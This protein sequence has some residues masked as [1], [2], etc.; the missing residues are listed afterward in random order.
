MNSNKEKIWAIRNSLFF[1]VI[2]T[3]VPFLGTEYTLDKFKQDE[4]LIIEHIIKVLDDSNMEI[5]EVFTEKEN[6]E[7]NII[8]DIVDSKLYRIF[9]DIIRQ[10][11]VE[12]KRN[13]SNSL[14]NSI[15]ESHNYKCYYCG[16]SLKKEDSFSMPPHIDHVR[17]VRSGGKTK[18]SNLVAS[19][20]KCNIG[21]RDYDI[22]LYNG[23]D[24]ATIMEN[25]QLNP[26]VKEKANYSSVKSLNRQRKRVFLMENTMHKHCSK[27]GAI[28]TKIY[29]SDKIY[30]K[31]CS[32]T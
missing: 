24:E 2:R 4:P 10:H 17:S 18:E 16:S 19:C 6:Q 11:Y 25:G 22:F 27:C 7:N 3:S 5:E 9:N 28:E 32:R 15:L 20:W 31:K 21:K 8:R 14:R 30:C 23:E 1:Y 29:V 26:H 13:I 12:T